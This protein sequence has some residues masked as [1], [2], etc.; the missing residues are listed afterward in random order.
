MGR[1]DGPTNL[2]LGTPLHHACYYG[3]LP[4]VKRLLELGARVTAPPPSPASNAHTRYSAAA[5]LCDCAPPVTH[6]PPPPRSAPVGFAESLRQ[7]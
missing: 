4:A 1:R 5:A 7:C 6:A 3:H 2:L